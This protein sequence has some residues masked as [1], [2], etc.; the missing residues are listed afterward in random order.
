MTGKVVGGMGI[1]FL[2]G[3]DVTHGDF[4]DGVDVVELRT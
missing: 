3:K 2:D 1:M 4:F